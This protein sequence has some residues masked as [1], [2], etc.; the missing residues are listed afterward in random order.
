MLRWPSPR[1]VVVR[2]DNHQAGDLAVRARRWLQRHPL[3]PGDLG[4][5]A[6]QFIEQLDRALGHALVLQRMNPREARQ[7]RHFFVHL[8]VVFHR[9]GA[10]GIEVGI[11]AKVAL[12]EMGEVAHHLDLA[13]LWQW[14]WL[15]AQHI[16]WDKLVQ[17]LR[18]H[19]HRGQQRG[20]A[21]RR[22]HLENQLLSAH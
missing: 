20:A 1:C 14:R 13:D 6:F 8:G 22:A 10:Q 5:I 2:L 3:H 19:I 9:A 11:H 4:Q 7:A 18:R 17:R 15:G 16:L 21:T 12:R